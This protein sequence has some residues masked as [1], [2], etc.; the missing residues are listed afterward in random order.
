VVSRRNLLLALVGNAMLVYQQDT[1]TRV[2]GTGYGTVLFNFCSL[3][4]TGTT[5]TVVPDIFVLA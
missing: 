4:D 3:L 5:G 2:P 1:E